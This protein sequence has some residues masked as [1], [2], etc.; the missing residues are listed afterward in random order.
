MA[1]Q[2]S[3]WCGPIPPSRLCRRQFPPLFPARRAARTLRAKLGETLIAMDAPPE[4]ENV[5]AFVNVEGLLLAAGVSV[6]AIVAD[7]VP[8]GF[9]L[10]SDLG[11]TTYLQ[12]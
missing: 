8:N 1:A 3:A 6:P 10:L 9:L 2:R 7:D 4:R 11:T 12:R 5:P